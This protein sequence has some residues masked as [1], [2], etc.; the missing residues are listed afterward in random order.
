MPINRFLVWRVWPIWLEITTA[1]ASYR[2]NFSMT[3]L[4]ISIT[5]PLLQ[6][7]IKKPFNCQPFSDLILG[8]WNLLWGPALIEET[9]ENHQP[10]GVADNALYVVQCDAL[11]FPGG[12]ILPVYVVAIAAT[13]PASLY[14]WETE[15]FQYRKLLTG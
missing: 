14:D 5:F 7:A 2:N 13:N 3:Y 11:A 6:Q 10:T 1:A 8:N 4:F 9:D 12:P 15:D